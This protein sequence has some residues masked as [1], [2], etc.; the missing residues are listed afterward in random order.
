MLV[1][2]CKLGEKRRQLNEC[3]SDILKSESDKF[4]QKIKKIKTNQEISNRKKN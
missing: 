4:L 3:W 1:T 2:K